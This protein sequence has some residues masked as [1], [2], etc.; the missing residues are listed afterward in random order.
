MCARGRIADGVRGRE[1]KGE[2]TK[3]AQLVS[4]SEVVMREVGVSHEQ[5]LPYTA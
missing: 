3:E 4:L 5:D 1:G 2:G